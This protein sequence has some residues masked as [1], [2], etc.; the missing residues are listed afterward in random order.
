MIHSE[1]GY[2]EEKHL[3]NPEEFEIKSHLSILY[4]N[5]N[6]LYIFVGCFEIDDLPHCLKACLISTAPPN[7]AKK[8]KCSIQLHCNGNEILSYNGKIL[9]IDETSNIHSWK[10]GNGLIY[11]KE[12]GKYPYSLKDNMFVM[13]VKVSKVD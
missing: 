9:S 12:V 3:T 13:L 7:K 8:L 6:L 11:P 4:Y 10:S 2:F 1:K 5:A